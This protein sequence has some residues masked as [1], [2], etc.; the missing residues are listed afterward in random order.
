MN[1]SRKN[2][3]L[4]W[5][6]TVGL[7]CTFNGSLLAQTSVLRETPYGRV[8]VRDTDPI[9][10]AQTADD[11]AAAKTTRIIWGSIPAVKNRKSIVDFTWDQT[12]IVTVISA[13]LPRAGTFEARWY[14]P[15]RQRYATTTES[16]R[17]TEAAG[18]RVVSTSLKFPSSTDASHSAPPIPGV[19]RV[20]LF[21]N[22]QQIG[23]QE[24]R[25]YSAEESAQ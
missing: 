24:I 17:Y 14:G 10:A 16:F 15:D 2:Q 9:L 7:L 21:I 4:L 20:D 13:D 25:F 8:E 12:A 6:L 5:F 22:N 19:W 3:Q 1:A 23:S 11:A 18:P